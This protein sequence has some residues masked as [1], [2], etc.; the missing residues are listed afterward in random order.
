[1]ATS[2]TH[3][4]ASTSGY[5]VSI[6][7]A[8]AANNKARVQLL[9]DM[10]SSESRNADEPDGDLRHMLPATRDALYANLV[11]LHTAITN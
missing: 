2:N 1:M 9:I 8:A 11:A 4:A 6:N 10:I 5:Q 3:L 7:Y